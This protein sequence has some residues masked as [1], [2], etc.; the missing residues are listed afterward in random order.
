MEPKSKEVSHNLYTPPPEPW[1]LAM[2]FTFAYSK[3]RV[4]SSILLL[5]ARNLRICL[6][7]YLPAG[8]RLGQASALHLLVKHT[9]LFITG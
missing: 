2:H 9:Y 1:P 5:Q 3:S 7:K 4:S 8:K 6:E